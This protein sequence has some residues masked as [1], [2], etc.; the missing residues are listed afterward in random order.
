LLIA[1]APLRISFGG[2]GTDLPAFYEREE[3]MV[4]SA[5]LAKYVYVMINS[6]PGQPIEITS[7]DFQFHYSQITE[8][9]LP[10]EGDLNLVFRILEEFGFRSGVS[11]FIASEVPPGTGL[12]SSGSVAVALIKALSVAR[13]TR[14][15]PDEVANLACNIEIDRIGSKVGKQDQYASSFGGVNQIRFT[16]DQVIVESMKLDHNKLIQLSSNLMLFFT[17]SSHSAGAILKEQADSVEA[18]DDHVT[19]SLQFIR[20]QADEAANIIAS[21]NC[22]PLGELMHQGW[23][24][25]RKLSNSVTTPFI[26]QCYGDALSAGATGGKI[27]GAGGGGFLLLYVDPKF[28]HR[29]AQKMGE[30]GL[31][32]MRCDIDS[33]GAMVVMNSGLPLVESPR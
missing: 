21:G 7:S 1:R 30:H 18:G 2:G 8:T 16:P 10:E 25:K 12:G 31:T 29:V 11:V 19:S 3:G 20:S 26:D 4:V 6:I 13:G 33:T 14:M 22:D 15:T 17:G 24:A 28:Q 23:M 32:P 5:A 27:T 9:A